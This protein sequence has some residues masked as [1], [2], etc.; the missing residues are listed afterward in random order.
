MALKF[1]VVGCGDAATSM[2]VAAGRSNRYE[3]VG[4]ASWKMDE[5][6][7]FSEKHGIG[8]FS[9]DQLVGGD[10]TDVIAITN[11]PGVHE[12]AAVAALSHGRH[13]I[14]EKPM[15]LD[16]DT[17]AQIIKAGEKS[18]AKLMVGHTHRYFEAA[19][20]IRRM[21]HSGKYGRLLM[22]E[23]NHSFDYFTAKRTGW[24][25]DPVLSGGGVIMNPVIHYTDRIR[26]F[27][28]SEVT[29]VSAR[30]GAAKP[31]YA[32]EG[33]VAALYTFEDESLSASLICNGYGHIAQDR[34]RIHLEEGII[35]LDFFDNVI[36]VY[37]NG[38]IAER[39]EP[40]PPPYGPDKLISGYLEEVNEFADVI[41]KNGESSSD[42]HNG[43][44][45]VRVCRAIFESADKRHEIRID[46]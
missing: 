19:R 43:R 39:L 46:N 9:L 16:E 24:Q 2:L 5:T 41:E 4:A 10:V 18:G 21:I 7:E 26:Y 38:V 31:G 32:I 12:A 20:M 36:T 25:L 34:T 37:Q 13:V 17:C 33:H 35:Q 28:G 6:K 1:G 8:A 22:I 42:G 40:N 23:E 27:A 29:A 15:A 14:V 11:P 45:N 30:Y 44:M 3:I